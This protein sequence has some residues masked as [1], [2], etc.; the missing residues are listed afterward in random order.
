[1]DDEGETTE[2]T[3]SS[4]TAT[5]STP[6]VT[7]KKPETSNHNG[8]SKTQRRQRVIQTAMALAA[9]GGYEAVVM[10]DLADQA[11]V[12]LGTLYNYFVSKDH[13]L[14]AAWIE[15]TEE[16]ERR[17]MSRPPQG[18]TAADRVVDVL[19]RVCTALGRQPKLVSAILTAASS[20]VPEVTEQAGQVSEVTYGMIRSAL[21]LSD[22][23]REMRVARVLGH[24][25]HSSLLAWIHGR[26]DISGVIADLDDAAHLLL[27]GRDE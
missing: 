23:D 12:A 4:S 14:A 21:A 15:W 9:E 22:P 27:D 10:R 3:V 5:A 11:N 25:L 1:M 17:I 19:G 2:I 8:N 7:R 26:T 16:L 6:A 18:D 20:V 13:L 24:V